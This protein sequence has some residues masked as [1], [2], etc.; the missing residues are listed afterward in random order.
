MD[1]FPWDLVNLVLWQSPTPR[2]GDACGLRDRC[3]APIHGAH[4]RSRVGPRRIADPPLVPPSARHLP[5]IKSGAGSAL[6]SQLRKAGEAAARK[7]GMGGASSSALDV[8]IADTI[9]FC[10]SPEPLLV[11]QTADPAPMEGS[12]AIY[13]L[14]FTILNFQFPFPP[15]QLRAPTWTMPPTCHC[16]RSGRTRHFTQS[17]LLT[18]VP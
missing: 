4:S 18:N 3:T 7:G 16:L 17:C 10:R 8:P 1:L 13:N 11:P 5:R 9:I 6:H 12:G 2:P 14:Q 15:K